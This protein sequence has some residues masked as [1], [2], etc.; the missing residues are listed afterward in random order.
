MATPERKRRD[1]DEA[2]SSSKDPLQSHHRK[3]AKLDNGT[4][5]ILS[6]EFSYCQ[7]LVLNNNSGN[8][9]Y[10]QSL[11]AYNG[12]KTYNDLDRL[13][14]LMNYHGF[15]TSKIASPRPALSIYKDSCCHDDI[16]EEDDSDRNNDDNK[17]EGR[18][19]LVTMLGLHP[20]QSQLESLYSS[21]FRQIYCLGLFCKRLKEI[22]RSAFTKNDNKTTLEEMISNNESTCRNSISTLQEARRLSS[23]T[24]KLVSQMIQLAVE[25]DAKYRAEQL[26]HEY[27][28]IQVWNS[29]F[30]N[31]LV[32]LF[33]K[34]HD[35]CIKDVYF[36][37][38]PQQPKYE[39]ITIYTYDSELDERKPPQFL[40]MPCLG[41]AMGDEGPKAIASQMVE[42]C[43]S[44]LLRHG[45]F[46]TPA[47]KEKLSPELQRFF[48][49]GMTHDL[50]V[51]LQLNAHFTPNHPLSFYLFGQA[52]AGKSSFVRNFQPALEATIEEFLDPEI[53][54]RFVKQNLNKRIEVLQ[55]EL[56][57][58][59][60]NNDLS[61][62]RIIQGRRM[63]RTQ[64]KPGLVVV[65]LE[66]MPSS[67]NLPETNPNQLD[68]AQLISQRFAGRKGGFHATAQHDCQPRNS[69]NRGIGNDAS[70]LT[71]FTSNYELG[72][73]PKEAL[74]RLKIFENLY[75]V[76]MTAV[77]GE[78]RIHF[79]MSYLQ[80]CIKDRFVDITNFQIV[81]LHIPMGDGDTRP[82]VRHLRMISFYICALI[83]NTQRNM[84][85]ETI[86]EIRVT[87]EVGSLSCIVQVGDE[88]T[89]LMVG[90]M[91]NL[92]PITRQI[93]DS[94]VRIAVDALRQGG[95]GITPAR[96]EYSFSDLS[97][98]L[99][100]WLAETLAP[101]VIVSNDEDRVQS[102]I[103]AVGLINGVHV[104]PKVNV[105]EYKMMKSLYDRNDM[106]NLRDDILKYGRGAFVA[107]EL[108][109]PSKDAQ[110]CI[111]E[112]I[113]DSPSMTAF[114]TAKSAL[115]KS[116]LLFA[117]CV[118]GEITPEVRSRASLI[119]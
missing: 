19:F 114:S 31:A 110:L 53:M 116:G 30:S 40:F 63:T 55:L 66:E 37:H 98:I 80:Q 77:S 99:D 69:Q 70:L 23:A 109:C 26:E 6:R 92:Y 89:E 72:S 39:R 65:D 10:P 3:K 85:D 96:E 88:S 46:T 95:N 36:K 28:R 54:C 83:E 11:S 74:R 22:C 33:Q 100:F 8:G 93:F 51:P 14:K 79:A 32:T 84:H 45:Y 104:I 38:C 103:R 102:L 15:R 81:Q 117:V 73:A 58:R 56:E 71:L 91:E 94:R 111:R 86:T 67:G 118:E 57:L 25:M 119:Y 107:T 24:P 101:A 90:K 12:N 108:K 47:L 106:R 61:V 78:D 18:I 29:T 87:Q 41:K 62:M 115:Y 48:L 21:T 50:K 52:G 27:Q 68:V 76:E 82:L 4:I 49:S 59:P 20:D 43:W 13:R 64:T 35:C 7:K 17:A 9:I 34:Q 113:E 1:D 5:T 75:C 112:I 97:I 42:S 16:R 44:H 2:T 105:D 60:N